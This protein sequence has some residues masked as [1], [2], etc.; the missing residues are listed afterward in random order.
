[1]I[2]IYYLIL[3]VSF[4]FT[5]TP[6]SATIQLDYSAA[7]SEKGWDYNLKFFPEESSLDTPSGITI[8]IPTGLSY[9]SSTLPP[10]QV[11]YNT[12][13][14]TLYLALT[15]PEPF[16]IIIEGDQPGTITGEIVDYPYKKTIPLPLIQ[17]NSGIVTVTDTIEDSDKTLPLENQPS[18]PGFSSLL[19][20]ISLLMAMTG[21]FAI[22]RRKL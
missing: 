19:T 9:I 10:S 16:S 4:L 6:V 5:L 11:R 17:L 22:E 8:S 15:S 13:T 20:F 7:P 1:M 14:N 12:D 3:S 21:Y 18:T 2:L